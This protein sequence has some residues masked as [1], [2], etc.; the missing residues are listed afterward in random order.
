[1]GCPGNL[2]NKASYAQNRLK[3]TKIVD[4]CLRATP[5]DLDLDLDLD[6]GIPR[7]PLGI[8]GDPQGIPGEQMYQNARF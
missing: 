3:P 8:P 2:W 7:D 1:M 5:L 4:S 6:L